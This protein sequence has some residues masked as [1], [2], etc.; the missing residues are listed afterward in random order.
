[1]SLKGSLQT[2]A[3]PEVLNFLADNGKSGVF[4]VS[5]GLGDGRL[6]FDH[7]RICGF[8]VPRATEPSEAI[9]GL[10]RVENGEFDFDADVERPEDAEAVS[11]EDG[12]VAPA[13]ESAEAKLVEWREIVAVVPSLQHRLQLRAD[14]PEEPVL[15][16]PAQWMMVVSIASGSTVGK[17][18]DDRGLQEF[19]GCKAVKGLVDASLVEVL[20]PADEPGVVEAENEPVVAEAGEEPVA[21][22]NGSVSEFGFSSSSLRFGTEPV[23]E[24]RPAAENNTDEHG[25]EADSSEAD[26]YAALRAA[27]LEVG[28]NLVTD[29]PEDEPVGDHPV[30][31]LP[32]DS[33]AHGRAALEALLSEVT[34]DSV[35]ADMPED[36]VDGL[37]DRGPWTEHELSSM[38]SGHEPSV[39]DDELGHV[40]PFAA[41]ASA[42]DGK[43]AEAAGEAEA[44]EAEEVPPAGEPINRGLLLKFLSSV[45]N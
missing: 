36:P 7:G 18:L 44:T 23:S 26:R 5:G 32:A 3:L 41:A 16:E 40:V 6:W 25:G 12:E 2:V 10:L 11:S 42:E 21:P 38:D 9:F 28:E 17:V 34:E 1:M 19:E 20:E 31:E 13:L 45:R 24:D 15:L 37:A 33:E 14:V 8:Q 29:Q 22:A 43:E 27:M 35:E 39:G 4:H 30:F